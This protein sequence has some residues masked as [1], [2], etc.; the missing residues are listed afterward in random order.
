MGVLLPALRLEP[1]R[2][3]EPGE[4]FLGRAVANLN[5]LGGLD[6]K[7]AYLLHVI[8]LDR[9]QINKP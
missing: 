7:D 2:L 8:I 1:E 9:D 5:D 3:F 6:R 4:N